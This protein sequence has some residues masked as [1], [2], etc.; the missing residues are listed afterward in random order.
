MA[1]GPLLK[2]RKT[3]LTDGM[4]VINLVLLQQPVVD[5]K[6]D[7]AHAN[8]DGRNHDHAPGASLAEASCTGCRCGFI[9][10]ITDCYYD[11]KEGNCPIFRVKI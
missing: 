3:G 5:Q 11:I 4:T 7:A 1:P 6:L 9:N 2:G 10:H 8:L